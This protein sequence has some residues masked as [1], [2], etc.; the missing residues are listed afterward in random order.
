MEE[1]KQNGFD[2]KLFDLEEFDPELIAN[3]DLALFIMATYGEG[4][5]TDNAAKFFK[6]LKNTDDAIPDN[7]LS[8]LKFSV[9][10]LGNRQYEHYNRMGKLVNTNLEKFG[11]KRLY[12]YGEGDDDGTLEEDFESW[13]NN[14]YPSL[15]AALST[16][17]ANVS[18]K[19]ESARGSFKPSNKAHLDYVVKVVGVASKKDDDI[20]HVES[21][22]AKSTM[23]YQ[24]STKHFF[25]APRAMVVTNRE[26]RNLD[27]KQGHEEVG[28]TR[29]IEIDLQGTGLTYQTADNLA[30]LPENSHEIVEL[31]AKQM[32]YNLDEIVSIEPSDPNNKD[33]K[34]TYPTPCT[35]RDLLT[36]YVDL[37]GSVRHSTLKNLSHY[38]SSPA[39]LEWLNDMIENRQ[40]F[41]H[42]FEEERLSLV[43]LFLGE[44]NTCFLPLEEL[45]HVA[46]PLQPRY[47]TISSSSSMHPTVVHIT[48][49]V[50]EHKLKHGRVFKGVCSNYLKSLVP[51][52]SACRIFVRPSTFR[53]PKSVSTPCIFIGPGTGLAPMRALLQERSVLLKSTSAA[54]Y[55]SALFYGCKYQA[56]DYIYKDEIQAFLDCG[57]LGEL[58][59]A[60]SRDSEKKV[61]VQHLLK[62]PEVAKRLMSWIF[63]SNA[64]IYVCGA[65]SMG[66][67]VM[68]AFVDM[69]QQHKNIDHD[70]AH[71]IIKDLQ[72]Q[73]RYIQELWSA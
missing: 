8:K 1:G 69:I 33:F 16:S 39:Q 17:D 56:M 64:Y 26:L 3:T 54:N 50:T 68:N 47:Y 49:S 28:S 43:D 31:I 72:Q 67:D 10:G 52:R 53:L 35:V 13:K 65:T 24:P 58:H 29:H 5:P 41:K 55:P 9:F 20:R 4:E 25:T 22:K 73:S 45:L 11:G 32:H 7:Y 14:L 59:T 37:T 18:A 62:D 19:R 21:T 38:V 12:D 48:V 30:V 6:W 61:Y 46:P 60:F 44:L 40:D 23:K 66:T 15:I 2:A 51:N 71:N 63:G 70:A 36:L 57:A 27:F 34:L 42:K